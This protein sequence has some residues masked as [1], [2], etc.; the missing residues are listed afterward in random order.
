MGRES[1][2]METGAGYRSEKDKIKEKGMAGESGGRLLPG[3]PHPDEAPPPIIPS[4]DCL[5]IPIRLRN[6]PE[7]LW[8]PSFTTKSFDELLVFRTLFA[9]DTVERA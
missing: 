9:W 1:R 2:W 6:P 8:S 3:I 4:H 7:H 5:H